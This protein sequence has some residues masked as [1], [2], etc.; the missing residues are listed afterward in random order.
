MKG[1]PQLRRTIK[2]T[3]CILLCLAAL[4]A[5]TACEDKSTPGPQAALPEGY[6]KNTALKTDQSVVLRLAGNNDTWPEMQAVIGKFEAVYPNCTVIYEPIEQY[7]SNL[8]MRLAQTEQKIDLFLT[9]NIQDDT[10]HKDFAL[11]LISDESKKILDLSR[12]NAGLVS[13]FRYVGA[14]NTQYAVPYG[15]EMRGM[16][17]NTTLLNTLGLKV[18]TNRKELLDCCEVLLANGYIPL[19]SSPGTFAQ[20]LLYPYICNMIV[21]GGDYEKMYHAV[22]TIEPG[23]SEYFRDAYALLYEIVEKGYYD[24]RRVEKELGYTFETKPLEFLNIV[25]VSEDAYEKRDDIGK[26]AFLPDTQAF[27]LRLEQAKADYHSAIEYE[28][29]PSPV[30]V[31]GGYAY[32]S[33]SDGLAINKNSDHIDWALEF[34][35]FF[36]VPEVNTVFAK[37]SGKIPNTAGA[38][39]EYDIP[40]NRACDVGQVTFSYGFYRTVTTPM[41][42]GFDDMIGISKMNNPKYMKDNGDGT[43]SLLFTLEEY[44]ARL[45]EE[46]QKVKQSQ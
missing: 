2:T 38:L 17:V 22:E 31:D 28:F 35:N 37:A 42:A 25:K 7:R 40:E 5:L 12:A 44:M 45:E 32:L 4:L 18:P 14:E 13:N 29:I 34:L 43:Y 33:P 20:Q 15:G 9:V 24:Y 46:F 10:P 41:L 11:N 26:A 3:L 30:G 1:M 19:Q 8:P 27:S 23:V 16:Y 21:N 6:K 39:L 36:F